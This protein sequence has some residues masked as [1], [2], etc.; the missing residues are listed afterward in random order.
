MVDPSVRDAVGRNN[1]YEAFS[2]RG[3]RV[4]TDDVAL[5]G[6]YGLLPKHRVSA[7]WLERIELLKGFSAL[8]SGAAARGA[9]AH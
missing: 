7:A 4:S 5:N 2:I 1:L 8:F 9:L 3:F 6:L